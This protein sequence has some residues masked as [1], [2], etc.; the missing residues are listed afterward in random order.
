VLSYFFYSEKNEKKRMSQAEAEG[1]VMPTKFRKDE[2][3]LPT[4]AVQAAFML[5]ELSSQVTSL[6]ISSNG[7]MIAC[8]CE[9]GNV[10]FFVRDYRN[11]GKNRWVKSSINEGQRTLGLG[12]GIHDVLFVGEEDEFLVFAGMGLRHL[13]CVELKAATLKISSPFR[14]EGNG[15]LYIARCH[16]DKNIVIMVNTE[17][18]TMIVCH[19]PTSM[20]LNT[21]ETGRE[22][23]SITISSDDRTVAVG[24]NRGVDIFALSHDNDRIGDLLQSMTE[25]NVNCICFSHDCNYLAY[26]GLGWGVRIH[27]RNERGVYDYISMEWDRPREYHAL[28]F[29]GEKNVLALG[30]AYTWLELCDVET[31]PKGWY[32]YTTGL[33]PPGKV[34]GRILAFKSSV[35]GDFLVCAVDKMPV[36]VIPDNDVD[37]EE[38]FGDTKNAANDDD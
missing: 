7:D 1:F 35:K 3:G 22:C 28:A 16:S 33:H 27:K 18:G 24:H 30:T 13:Y 25:Y 10:S 21:R 36:A 14:N 32:V 37:V 19:I 4:F 6:C 29:V 11:G 20:V 34:R 23:M 38:L 9:N 2:R 8:G 31:N 17:P 26:A 5:E 12:Y 15:L